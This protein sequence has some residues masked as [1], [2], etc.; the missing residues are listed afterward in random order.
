MSCKKI[1]KGSHF[2]H[3]ESLFQEEL[4]AR[5]NLAV[6]KVTRQKKK[7]IEDNSI[8]IDMTKKILRTAVEQMEEN[9]EIPDIKI[10]LPNEEEDFIDDQEDFELELEA[11]DEE[12][13]A[14]FELF[15]PA[16]LEK[17]QKIQDKFDET[18]HL[19][20]EGA[21]RVYKELGQLL[22]SYKS[23]KLPKAV[24]VV[25]SQKIGG[26]FELLNYSNP[27]EWTVNALKAVTVL[28]AQTASDKRCEKFYRYI[29]LE[30]IR[31]ILEKSKK[32]PSNV[33]QALIAAS[34]RSKPFIKSILDPFSKEIQCTQKEARVISAII[35]RIKLPHD[36]VNAFLIKLCENQEI[37]VA[38]TIFVARFVQKGQ[39]LAIRTIDAIFAY[40]IQF[41]S[42]DEQQP[43]LWHKA[44]LDFVK[45]YGKELLEEQKEILFGLLLK[46]HHT[47]ITPEIRKILKETNCR[48]Y[49]EN[50]N[51]KFIPLLD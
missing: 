16:I 42:L 41:N 44:L 46:H 1:K 2:N 11:N 27:S 32:L 8:G 24:N 40:F 17:A 14:L 22:K 49:N 20:N 43:I 13:K 36:H 21:I 12:S 38:R 28:F 3:Q 51:N 35:N 5:S 15:K 37:T 26:W 29:L 30:N 7:V 34:R 23:G 39:V 45:R 10:D 6:Q 19:D 50:D 33:W 31:D 18:R 25:A 9:K 47:N 4:N 48:I